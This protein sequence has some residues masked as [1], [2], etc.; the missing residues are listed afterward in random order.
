MPRRLPDPR[1]C[2]QTRCRETGQNHQKPPRRGQGSGSGHWRQQGPAPAMTRSRQSRPAA[3]PARISQTRSPATCPRC[4][5]A[6]TGTPARSPMRQHR[7][8]A[9]KT[10]GQIPER[11]ARHPKEYRVRRSPSAFRSADGGPA[12]GQRPASQLRQGKVSSYGSLLINLAGEGAPGGGD[13][14]AC[15]TP[16]HPVRFTLSGASCH[17]YQAGLLACGSTPI[18]AFPIQCAG[19]VACSK[20]AHRV[21]SRGRLRLL[22]P[23]WVSSPAFPFHLTRLGLLT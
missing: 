11:D 1:C 18:S 13:S 8:A 21:Q 20:S 2:Q 12:P 7:P 5:T 14:P 23:I 9:R 17:R 6:A 22:V 3:C 19:S 10:G 4:K 16:K 15:A